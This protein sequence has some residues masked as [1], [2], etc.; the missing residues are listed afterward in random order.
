[1]SKQR[2]SVKRLRK[3]RIAL[4]LIKAEILSALPSLDEADREWFN[5]MRLRMGN[6]TSEEERILIEIELKV[7]QGKIRNLTKRERILR[8]DITEKKELSGNRPKADELKRFAKLRVLVMDAGA[9][10]LIGDKKKLFVQHLYKKRMWKTIP[11]NNL[12]QS[13]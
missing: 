8:K 4:D 1:M 13:V 6:V 11:T 7:A 5:E 3:R 2:P 10:L 12:I 9:A